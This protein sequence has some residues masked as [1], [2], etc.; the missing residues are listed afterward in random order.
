[1]YKDKNNNSINMKVAFTIC[2]IKVVIKKKK[3]NL[4]SRTTRLPNMYREIVTKKNYP[5]YNNLFM[6]YLQG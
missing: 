5:L 2:Y 3:K 1:M 6:K 4:R